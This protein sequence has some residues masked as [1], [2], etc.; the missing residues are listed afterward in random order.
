[1]PNSL[2]NLASVTDQRRIF[3][4]HLSSRSDRRRIPCVI[5][6]QELIDA[7]LL[8]LLFYQ[9]VHVRTKK[10]LC[11]VIC[12]A[13]PPRLSKKI[14]LMLKYMNSNTGKTIYKCVRGEIKFQKN[15][16]S[17]HSF[18]F[19]YSFFLGFFVCFF[20]TKPSEIPLCR[21]F[22]HS[23][24]LKWHTILFHENVITSLFNVNCKLFIL[25]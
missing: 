2:C 24:F 14:K 7:V 9:A 4:C 11:H 17:Q 15:L 19:V 5:Y 10:F 21:Y 1:M 20:F 13:H 3:L 16:Y 18:H 8:Y 12:P 22:V 23:P 25:K 6:H